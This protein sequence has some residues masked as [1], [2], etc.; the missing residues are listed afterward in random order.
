[1]NAGRGG[2]TSINGAIP[3]RGPITVRT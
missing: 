2:Q 1:L 3:P